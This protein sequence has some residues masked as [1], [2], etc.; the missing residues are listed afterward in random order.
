MIDQVVTA[1]IDES[2]WLTGSLTLALVAS[3]VFVARHRRR[4]T[5]DRRT[6]VLATLTLF[7]GVTIGT[8]AFG[9]LLAISVKLISHTLVGST[10][11]FYAIGLL[12]AVP[13]GVLV[14]HALRLPGSPEHQKTRT[15]VLNGWLA[16]TLLAL[17]PHNFP[18]AM[19]GLLNIAYALHSRPAVG[20]SVAA[21][22]ALVNVGLFAGS[23]VFLASG[24]SFE[25]FRGM[26]R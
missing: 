19:P 22:A 26:E 16:L 11:A 15:T 18:L 21:L 3:A 20:W 1:I 14:R 5:G 12:L 9:H 2:K 13:A 4:A 8:M 24:Q 23:L 10:A 17:G 7:F 6:I 25:Q